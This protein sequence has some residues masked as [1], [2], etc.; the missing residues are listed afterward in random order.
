MKKLSI[1]LLLALC[2]QTWLALLAPACPPP[3]AQA[4]AWALKIDALAAEQLAKPGGVGLSIAV[5]R[6]GQVLFS[7]GYGKAEVEFDVPADELTMFRIGSVTKQFTAALVLR[8]VEQGKLSLDD[9]LSKFVPEFPLHDHK[10]TIRQLLQHTSGIKSY[11]DV[12]EAWEKLWPLE[13][14]HAELLALVSD[15]PFDFEPGS[16]WR[17]NNTGYYL[18]GMLVEK[19]SGVSYGDCLVEELCKPLGLERTRYDSNRA[20]IKNRAQGYSLDKGQLLNDQ[21]LGMAQPGG[22]GGMLSTAGDLV[23]WQMALTAGEFVSLESFEQMRTPCALPSGR[24]TNYG[25]GLMIDDFHGKPRVQH[26]GGIFGFNSMLMWLPGED[27]HIAVIS[28]G[29]PI[30]SSKLADAIGFAVLGLERPHVKDEP[31][32]AELIAR[33]A[34]DYAL[35]GLDLDAR[36]FEQDGKL[37]LQASGQ[38]A[39]RLLWQGTDEFRADFDND[40]RLVFAADGQSLVLF[41]AGGK[42]DGLRK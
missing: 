27:L 13:L 33:I 41:Q 8:F 19:L 5:A 36:V 6:K 9:D 3:Q 17:Y 29:E 28:N 15:A 35:V 22:A 21:P 38:G 14:S 11:T 40:V 16:D 12:G 42:F 30:S 24:N 4:P 37:M 2:L 18:L 20:L 26:G 7:K 25:F 10:V 31:I 34:A 39:F 23:R 32:P 1:S